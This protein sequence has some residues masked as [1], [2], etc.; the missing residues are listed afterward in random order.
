M[1]RKEEQNSALKYSN[2]N[3]VEENIQ[4]KTLDK[5]PGSH[6]EVWYHSRQRIREF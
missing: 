6:Q 2:I 1:I 5:K 4:G 3:H